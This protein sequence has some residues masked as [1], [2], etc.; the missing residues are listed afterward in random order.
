MVEIGA[1]LTAVKTGFDLI[2]HVRE[3][4][5]KEKPDLQEISD[6]LVELQGLLLDARQ[7]L[8]DADEEKCLLR[9]QLEAMRVRQNQ[10]DDM[11]YVEDGGFY[12]RKSEKEA[13]KTIAYCPLC[14]TKDGKAVVLGTR[15]HGSYWCNHD[16]SSYQTR[17][18]QNRSGQM[19]SSSRGGYVGPWS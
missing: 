17:Q 18:F 3:L 8:A 9:N 14:W 1:G 13:G 2:K 11:E 16:R 6:K 10:I 15:G 4:T 5:K 12:I 19:V 7:A